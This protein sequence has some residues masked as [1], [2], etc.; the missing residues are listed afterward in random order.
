MEESSESVPLT[1]SFR[2]SL[3]DVVY[4]KASLSGKF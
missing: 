4:E 2:G 1:L 3:T